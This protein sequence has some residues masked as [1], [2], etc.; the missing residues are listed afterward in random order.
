MQR[1]NNQKAISIYIR[2]I[3]KNYLYSKENLKNITYKEI[4]GVSNW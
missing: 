1:A 3:T 2:N 4:I